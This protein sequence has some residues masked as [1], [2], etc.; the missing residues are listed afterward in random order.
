[1]Q[2]QQKRTRESVLA[3]SHARRWLSSDPIGT[4]SETGMRNEIVVETVSPRWSASSR[5]WRRRLALHCSARMPKCKRDFDGWQL[6]DLTQTA[7]GYL[8]ISFP[9]RGTMLPPPLLLRPQSLI[10]NTHAHMP[11]ACWLRVHTLTHSD[12]VYPHA[13][14]LSQR[15][16]NHGCV[17]VWLGREPC[18]PVI[19]CRV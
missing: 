14:F 1:M 17:R 10:R 16:I 11:H 6:H 2:Q 4:L 8:R 19:G 18:A 9:H 5:H 7:V 3:R 15:R 12:C 13:A